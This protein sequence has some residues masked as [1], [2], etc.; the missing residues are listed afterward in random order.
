MFYFTWPTHIELSSL[1]SANDLKLCRQYH[2]N[3]SC[4]DPG[5]NLMRCYHCPA[6]SVS[7]VLLVFGRDED[8]TI[9]NYVIA[10]ITLLA[11]HRSQHQAPIVLLVLSLPLAWLED[12]SVS[13][14]RLSILVNLRSSSFVAL[15]FHWSAI[16]H[17][18]HQQGRKYRS[19]G[20]FSWAWV[21]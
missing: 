17:A 8:C 4:L 12:R 1:L 7:E 21:Q 3:P 6:W 18:P 10:F 13:T 20:L 5:T 11:S 19:V 15:S 9:S 2:C 16:L 14:R